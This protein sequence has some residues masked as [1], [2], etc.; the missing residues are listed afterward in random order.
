MAEI[1]DAYVQEQR[2]YTKSELR[3]KFSFNESEVERFIKT[4]KA[5]GVL[6]AVKYD[7]KQ[8]DMTELLDE[9]IEIIDETAGNR[10]CFY[11]FT[12][13]GVI[14]IGDRVIKAYPK[15]IFSKDE[16]FEEIKQVIKVLKKYSNSQEQIVNLYNGSDEN[17]SFNMLAVIL[18]LLND[19]H[20]YGVY[21]NSEDITEINGEGD[22]LWGRTIDEG[23]A[24]IENNTPYYTELYTH[25]SVD[26]EMDYFKRLHEC[27]LTECSQQLRDSQLED[28]FQ[29]VTVELS[30]ERLADFGD[31]EYIKDRILS[32]LNI[33]FNTRKQILLKTLYAYVSQ[34]KKMLDDEAGISMFGTTAFNMVWENACAE[35]FDNKLDKKVGQ[36]NLPTDLHVDYYDFEKKTLIEIIKPPVWSRGEDIREEASETLRPDLISITKMKG[37]NYFI[38]FDAK[39]YNLTLEKGKL[40]GNPGVGDVDKQY[41]YQLAYKDFI[42][43]HGFKEVRNCFLMPTEKDEVINAGTASMPILSALGLV[44]IAIR[45][46]PARM[47]FDFYLLQKKFDFELLQ[48]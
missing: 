13:V 3:D 35:V 15:Y 34:D 31:T 19:Y 7:S 25:R 42:L 38:I 20:E 28:I 43:A 21:N 6:K 32:E 48:L 1:K 29:I 2:R 26:D 8:Q 36:L 33:Q 39:Y 37:E 44:D 22:I 41:L 18:F 10:D 4:L 23:F 11:V 47:L 46:I 27:I 12:Y 16:P 17:R 30:D 9:D 45:K 14:T 5:Y 24:Y 40:S